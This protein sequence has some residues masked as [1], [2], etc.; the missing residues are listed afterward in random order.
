MVAGKRR[1]DIAAGLVQRE[2]GLA[3]EPQPRRRLGFVEGLCGVDVRFVGQRAVDGF[4]PFDGLGEGGV[5]LVQR[6][7]AGRVL[8]AD[9]PLVGNVRRKHL[10]RAGE[11]APAGVVRRAGDDFVHAL[12]EAGDAAEHLHVGPEQGP[13]ARPRRFGVVDLHANVVAVVDS[14]VE[15]TERQEALAAFV[16][17]V[18]DGT[19]PER[20][21]DDA[22]EERSSGCRV[23]PV[24]GVDGGVRQLVH[25]AGDGFGVPGDTHSLPVVGRLD[26]GV[27]FAG[28]ERLVE[29]PSDGWRGLHH[30]E[31]LAEE[32]RERGGVDASRCG[33]DS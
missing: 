9:A 4:G 17:E 23:V 10:R 16:A 30:V 26:R 22:V 28:F 13:V 6:G 7:V 3:A 15:G 29:P 14:T 12:R 18:H 33:F 27:V 8:P 20:V 25:D 32:V 5:H 2:P 19:A 11:F 31:L 24:E 1:R 21:A